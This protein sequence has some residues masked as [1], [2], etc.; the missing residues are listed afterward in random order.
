MKSC[1]GGKGGDR[2]KGLDRKAGKEGN[3]Q[4]NIHTYFMCNYKCICLYVV[5]QSQE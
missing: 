5:M 1:I 2:F 4:Q 3:K